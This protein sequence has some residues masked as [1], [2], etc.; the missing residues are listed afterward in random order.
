MP[1]S[2]TAGD[3]KFSLKLE[4]DNVIFHVLLVNHNFSLDKL[5]SS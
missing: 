5:E 4:Q 1:E 3:E 2:A